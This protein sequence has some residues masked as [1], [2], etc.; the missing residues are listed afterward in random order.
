MGY[1]VSNLEVHLL[2]TRRVRFGLDLS[3][4]S[5]P[6]PRSPEGEEVGLV[7]GQASTSVGW[8][9]RIGVCTHNSTLELVLV[10]KYNKR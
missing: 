2:A 6:F 1:D 3:V 7:N 5:L 8:H 4:T 10:Y 9:W